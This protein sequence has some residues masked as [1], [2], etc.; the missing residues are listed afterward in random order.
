MFFDPLYLLFMAPAMLLAMWAQYRVKSAF[1]RGNEIAASGG[2]SGAEAARKILWANGLQRVGIEPADGHLG[3][4]Y[5]PRDKVLRLSPEVYHGRSVASVGV[6]AHEAGHAIQDAAHYGP[7]KLRNGIVPLA[8]TGSQL[9]WIVFFIG[10][11]FSSRYFG[12]VMMVA[13]IALFSLVVFFQLVNLPV[14]FDASRRARQVLV[15]NG[16]VTQHEDPEVARVLNA[17]AMTY[18]AATLSAVMSLLYLVLRSGLLGGR[19]EE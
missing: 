6:A 12:Q 19:R 7:L 10:L 14:E 8:N 17:A 2:M 13:G 11:V 18:V 15:S 9:S 1:A 5:D 4:H 3:D 16:I